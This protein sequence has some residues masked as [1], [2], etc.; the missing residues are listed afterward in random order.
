MGSL[1]RWYACFKGRAGWAFEISWVGVELWWP[2]GV[3]SG[4]ERERRASGAVR[5]LAT[6]QRCTK[7]SLSDG[8][9]RSR[10]RGVVHMMG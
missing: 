8:G 9:V 10:D 6:S 5:G 3:D 2:V 4:R 7:R 1:V